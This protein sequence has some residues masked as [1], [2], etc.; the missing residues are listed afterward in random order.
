MDTKGNTDHHTRQVLSIVKALVPQM[1]QNVCDRAMQLH[2]AGGLSQDTPLN[3]LWAGARMLR[4]ADGP[5]EVHWR[6]AGQLELEYQRESRLRPIGLYT[7]A[8]DASE[9]TFRHTTD[10]LS[11]EA[12]AVSAVKAGA[13]V[14]APDKG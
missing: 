13:C 5:D 6:K 12:S 7:P 9:P 1:V 3:A 2:G 10:P 11:A 8:R 14:Q 4:L